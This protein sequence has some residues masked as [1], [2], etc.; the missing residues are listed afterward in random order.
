MLLRWFFRGAVVLTLILFSGF[1]FVY[2]AS[3]AHLRSFAQPLAFDLP[4]PVD[5]EAMSRGEHLVQ[6]RGCR[7][8]H[9]GDLAGK[10]MWDFALA[11]NLVEY[12]QHETPTTFEAALRH[13]IGRDGR[14]LYSM[15]S[16]NFIRLRDQD[17][18]EIIGYLRT[19]PLVEKDLA[20]PS[21]PWE[22]RKDIAL[23]N[24]KAIAQYL[25]LVP[26]LQH[27]EN[28]NSS[29]ARGEYLAMTTCNECHGFSL[30]ADSPWDD[31]TAPDLI[32]VQAYEEA[33]FRHLMKTGIAIGEREVGLMSMVARSRFAHF[34][35]EEVGDLY[36]FLRD[37]SKKANAP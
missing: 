9:G 33:A 10:I 36:H 14:A 12:A 2:L 31:E 20:T 23:G 29:L 8:C 24:D 21:L 1:I 3:E 28:P 5:A 6:T 19:V 17:V 13:A 34:T 27:Q 32:I 7:G 30:R 4:I 16:Y 18:A 25:D 35:D 37:M 11:P 26:A 15:P 22:I